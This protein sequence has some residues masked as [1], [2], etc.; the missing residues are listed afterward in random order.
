MLHVADRHSF[1]VF[2]RYLLYITGFSGAIISPTLSYTSLIALS[3]GKAN[4]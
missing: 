4:I 3:V 1:D 2:T